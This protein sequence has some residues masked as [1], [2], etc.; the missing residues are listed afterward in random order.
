MP[1]F[2][3]RPPHLLTVRHHL[4]WELLGL[5]V[6]AAGL[7]WLAWFLYELLQN[8]AGS[9]W[10]SAPG[11]LLGVVGGEMFFDEER[12][13]FDA[14]RKLI[15]WRRPFRKRRTYGFE[16]VA[17]VECRALPARLLGGRPARECLLRFADGSALKVYRGRIADMD[18]LAAK[19]AEVLGKPLDP[20]DAG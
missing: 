20:Q 11:F 17:K 2:D 19:V 6:M 7:G 18:R 13:V 9:W 8:L 4:A 14:R 3:F 12:L 1:T 16:A 15:H 5:L 10:W